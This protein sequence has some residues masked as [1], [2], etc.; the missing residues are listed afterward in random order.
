MLRRKRA[1]PD[2][3]RLN[4]EMYGVG[5]VP[6]RQNGSN[7]EDRTRLR[8]KVAANDATVPATLR[9]KRSIANT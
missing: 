6:E 9:H 2:P 3:A 1:I 5:G 4:P 7:E 8:N